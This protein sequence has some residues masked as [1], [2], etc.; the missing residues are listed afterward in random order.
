MGSGRDCATQGQ[1]IYDDKIFRPYPAAAKLGMW[2]IIERERCGKYVA[3]NERSGID[4][5]LDVIDHPC[6][7][8]HS[9]RRSVCQT[10]QRY[11]CKYCRKRQPFLGQSVADLEL[12]MAV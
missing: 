11:C 10:A 1:I 9:A 7:R 5:S 12:D 3:D 8:Y 2:M 4:V 6:K